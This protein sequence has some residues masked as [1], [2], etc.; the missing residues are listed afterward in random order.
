MKITKGDITTHRDKIF[1]FD[2]LEINIVGDI[3]LKDSKRLIGQL[4]NKFSKNRTV[5]FPQYHINAVEHHTS[6]IQLN[7][8]LL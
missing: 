2:N 3:T 7:L 4:T 8:I 6:L 5:P 1:N